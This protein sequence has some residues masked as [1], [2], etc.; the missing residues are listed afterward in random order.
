MTHSETITMYDRLT[1]QHNE[2]TTAELR[3]TI[4]DIDETLALIDSRR[5]ELMTAIEKVDPNYF[6]DEADLLLV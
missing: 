6:V 4:S 1:D 5:V 2:L 3:G